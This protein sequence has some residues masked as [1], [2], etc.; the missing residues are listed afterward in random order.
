MGTCTSKGGVWSV[1]DHGPSDLFTIQIFGCLV[2]AKLGAARNNFHM[3]SPVCLM[4][5][6]R[7]TYY[8]RILNKRF[9]YN[10]VNLH[11]PYG[12]SLI[13]WLPYFTCHPWAEWCI[14]NWAIPGVRQKIAPS[15]PILTWG[16]HGR[17]LCIWF[18]DSVECNRSAANTMATLQ[19]LSRRQRL[20]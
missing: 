12:V 3:M 10:T 20:W 2:I 9:I 11:T 13:S 1:M 17:H 5:C 6:P 18:G 7:M 14:V 15:C 4:K 19:L 8:R 16:H